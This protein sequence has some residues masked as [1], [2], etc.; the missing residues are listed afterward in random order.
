LTIIDQPNWIWQIIDQPDWVRQIIGCLIFPNSLDSDAMQ[1]QH[2]G[3]SFGR[4]ELKAP[5]V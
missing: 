3:R 2:S 1:L 4:P 5:L